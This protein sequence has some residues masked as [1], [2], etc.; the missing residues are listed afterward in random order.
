M[1]RYTM[2]HTTTKINATSITYRIARFARLYVVLYPKYSWLT[3]FG[4][5]WFLSVFWFLPSPTLSFDE[6]SLDWP[7]LTFT[8]SLSASFWQV[9]LALPPA[10]SFCVS[11]PFELVYMLVSSF[12]SHVG[13]PSQRVGFLTPFARGDRA[14]GTTQNDALQPL[15]GGWVHP[16]LQWSWRDKDS[17]NDTIDDVKYKVVFYCGKSGSITRRRR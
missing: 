11:L 16:S 9:D 6:G 10:V 12:A 17:K 15:S 3:L 2:Q 7:W 14:H 5:R 4:S 8:L 13:A 1:G